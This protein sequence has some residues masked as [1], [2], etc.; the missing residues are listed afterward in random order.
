MQTNRRNTCATANLFR[1]IAAAIFVAAMPLAAVLACPLCTPSETLTEKLTKSDAAVLVRWIETQ[2]PMGG[3]LGSA[4]YEVLR[5]LKAPPFETSVKPGLRIS[6]DRYRD[7]KPGDLF[8]LF[9][10]KPPMPEKSDAP[11]AARPLQW[12]NDPQEITQVGYDY[13][14]QAPA[15]DIPV[16]KRLEYFLKFLEHPD[17]TIANDAYAEFANAPYEDITPLAA[18]LPR[19]KL[20]KWIVD[21]ETSPTHLGLYGLMLGLCGNDDDLRLMEAKILEKPI[22]DVDRLGIDGVTSGYLLLAKEK[23]LDLVDRT[24]LRDKDIPFGETY[25]AMQAL[26]FVWQYAEGAIPK[27]R[28]RRSMR[29]LLDRPELADVVIADLTRWQDW[30]IQDRLVELYGFDEYNVFEVKRAIVFYLYHSTKD[31]PPGGEELPA[32]AAKGK[33]LLAQLEEKDPKGVRDALRQL[34]PRVSNKKD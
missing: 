5:V 1:A 15:A 8:L 20:R 23:G 16:T 26:R 31:V 18:Q 19:E 10:P 17:Q 2:K 7:A 28:L 14:E 13:L 24:K 25:A 29:I 9:A 11:V 27:D 34:M 33:K 4:S 12:R 21:P 6:V 32:H 22:A 3:N 30:S